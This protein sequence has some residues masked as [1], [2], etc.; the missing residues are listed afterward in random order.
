MRWGR[1]LAEGLLIVASVYL[2]I[3]LEGLSQEADRRAEA[4]V[5]LEQL[6]AELR[7][8]LSDIDRIR[9]FQLTTEERLHTVARLLEDPVGARLDSIAA[10][11]REI[12]KA[13]YTLY[14]RKGAW[15]TLRAGGL[16][17]A[18]DDQELVVRIAD[19][20]E[21]FAVRVEY[22]GALYDTQYFQTLGPHFTQST[23]WPRLGRIDEPEILRSRVEIFAEAW[24]RYYVDLLDTYGAQIEEVVDDIER[25]LAGD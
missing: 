6:V 9:G 1:L 14:P 11:A 8:D 21:N 10:V 15:T 4:R 16:L 22:N 24:T 5:S 2:A 20:Y 17:A 13:N 18:V 3:F 25:Y 7:L 19:H 23:S 12:N